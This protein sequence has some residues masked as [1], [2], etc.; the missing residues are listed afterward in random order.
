MACPNCF[1]YYLTFNSVL[2]LI[3]FTIKL[4]YIKRYKCAPTVASWGTA[5]GQSSLS[6]ARRGYVPP[7]LKQN[8]KVCH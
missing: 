7:Q 4:V 8:K 6:G 2:T 3:K 1:R 5:I